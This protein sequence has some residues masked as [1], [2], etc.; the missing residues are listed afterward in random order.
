LFFN[1][2]LEYAN[3]KVQGNEEEMELNGKQHLLFYADN[4][5]LNENLIIIKKTQKLS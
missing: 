1:F 3:R 4:N 5:I 2:A